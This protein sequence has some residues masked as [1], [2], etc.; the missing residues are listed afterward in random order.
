M[1]K[2]NF[3][4]A[5]IIFGIIIIPL[6]YSTVYLKAFWNPYGKLDK[7]PVALINNDECIKNCMGT[8]LINELNKSGDFKYSVVTEK[9]GKDGLNNKKYY[10]TISIPK[11]FTK[12]LNNATNENRKK[13]VV[14]YSPNNKTN[15]LASQILNSAVV[16]I[17]NQLLKEST[18]KIV[19]TLSNKLKD[20]PNETSLIS[21]GLAR[22]NNGTNIVKNGSKTLYKGTNKLNVNYNEFNNGI[23]NLNNGSNELLNKYKVFNSG[24]NKICEGTNQLNTEASGLYNFVKLINYDVVQYGK[25]NTYINDGYN[26]LS[27]LYS[28]GLLETNLELKDKVN[29]Y[30]NSTNFSKEEATALNKSLQQLKIGA[31]T[32]IPRLQG[33]INSL[34]ANI[35]TLNNG[36]NDVLNG[37]NT[38]NNGINTLNTSSDK[39]KSGINELNNGTNTLYKG[40]ETL[41]NGVVSAKNEVDNKIKKTKKETK[42]LN[43]LSTYSKEPIKVKEK[44]VS[45]INN[46]GEAFAPYFISLSLWV[47]GILILVGLYYDPERRFKHLGRDTNNKLLTVGL[48]ALIG[49][50]QALIL[51]SLL[52]LFLDFNITN[53][54]LYYSSC[55]IISIT[56]LSIILFFFFHFKDVGKFLAIFMLVVQLAACGGTFPMETEPALYQAIYPYMPMTYSVD[57]LKQSLVDINNVYLLKNLSVLFGMWLLFSILTIIFGII[58]EK[59]KIKK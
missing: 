59:I 57:L 31:N 14:K 16:R 55:V 34:N 54:F 27:E 49:I 45:K 19:D 23:I 21:D 38:L 8:K 24:V 10:A 2:L 33:G 40:S 37:I 13:T 29:N 48:Y 32:S 35:N 47:G 58:K 22:I 41:N 18:G 6:I 4:K 36:S 52:H 15:F 39:I 56:F 9:E 25:A 3:K 50:I 46:Y 17:E 43:G 26:L 11:D 42:K 44:T 53:I 20:V 1:K 51:G 5:L 28:S 30:L 7:V 12:S